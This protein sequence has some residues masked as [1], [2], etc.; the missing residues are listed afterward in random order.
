MVSLAGALDP[1]YGRQRGEYTDTVLV[2]R[3]KIGA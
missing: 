1:A 3:P 2:V